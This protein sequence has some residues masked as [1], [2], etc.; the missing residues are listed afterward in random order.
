MNNQG[1]AFCSRF[2]YP[3]NS[4]SLCGPER[5]SD[6]AWYTATLIADQATEEILSQFRTLYPY[7]C[8]IAYENDIKDPFDSR[9]VEAY[10]LGNN[11]LNHVSINPFISHISDKLALKKRIARSH[12]EKIC[13]KIGQG[14]LPNH[15]FHVLNIYQRT[16]NIDSLHTIQSLDACIINWG[17]VISLSKNKITVLTKPLTR[18]RDALAFGKSKER[19]LMTHGT[20][21]VLARNIK[22]GDWVSYHWGYFCHTLSVRQL[23][24]LMY[25]TRLSLHFANRIA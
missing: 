13:V 25:Y 22:L 11:L 8:L 6:L 3:P 7:L 5:Q 18:M 2:S 19:T 9:V 24:N 17:K 20:H 15:S 14:A 1:L 4:F 23:E 12:L 16:G 10:W 21:D